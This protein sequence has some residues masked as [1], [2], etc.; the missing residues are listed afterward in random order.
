MAVGL[1]EQVCSFAVRKRIDEPGDK[2]LLRVRVLWPATGVVVVEAV[3]EVDLLTVPTLSATVRRQLEV[4]PRILV[5]DL[6]EVRFLG[7][8][9]LAVL[10]NVRDLAPRIGVTLRVARPSWAVRRPLDLLSLRDTFDVREDLA[11]AVRD[12]V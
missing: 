2:E 11:V 7:A 10:L 3:G 9:G 4:R 6:H 5:L 1:L 8:A 12:A